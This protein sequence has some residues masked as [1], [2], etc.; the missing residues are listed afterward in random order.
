MIELPNNRLILNGHRIFSKKDLYTYLTKK[1]KKGINSELEIKEELL[2]YNN[3]K[4]AIW[5]A[6]SFLKEESKDNYN[7]ILDILS[8]CWEIKQTWLNRK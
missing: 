5:H 8:S 3:L 6:D 2:K 4:I 1:F 7:K